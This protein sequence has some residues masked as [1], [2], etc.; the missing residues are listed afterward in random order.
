MYYLKGMWIKRVFSINY[1]D[2]W[3]EA[4]LRYKRTMR[5]VYEGIKIA[6][7]FTHLMDR[8]K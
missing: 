7:N 4:L 6:T 3:K 5:S 2:K 1:V 8:A